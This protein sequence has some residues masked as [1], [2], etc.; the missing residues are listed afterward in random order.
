[1]FGTGNIKTGVGED[2]TLFAWGKCRK[3][4]RGGKGCL[5]GKSDPWGHVGALREGIKPWW[6]SKRKRLNGK[7]GRT[8]SAKK[9]RWV[10]ESQMAKRSSEKFLNISQKREGYWSPPVAERRRP[11][12][13]GKL[14]Q[15][16][17]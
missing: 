4:W 15:E 6:N 7:Q 13:G 3:G 12:G 17:A 10:P 5:G 9:S 14:C 16:G 2:F 1:L 8:N 11:G